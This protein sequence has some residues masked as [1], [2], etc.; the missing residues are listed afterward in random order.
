MTCFIDGIPYE[1]REK[2][3]LSFLRAYGQV[4]HVFDILHS[5]TNLRPQFIR[6]SVYQI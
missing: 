4:F 3:D 1:L 6:H 5:V 2:T